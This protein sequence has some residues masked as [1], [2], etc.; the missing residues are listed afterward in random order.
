MVE[1]A[2]YCQR[3]NRF[4][5]RF[6]HYGRP[7]VIGEQDRFNNNNYAVERR[8]FWTA[9]VSGYMMGRVDRHYAV[10][11][12]G[13]LHESQIF[14][15]PADPPIYADLQRMGKFVEQSR[16]SFWRMAPHDELL[17]DVHGDIYCLAEPEVEYLLYFVMGGKVELHLP[18]KS[19]WYRWYN[20]RTGQFSSL[21][22]LSG[23][24]SYEFAA[25]DNE[26]W[27]LHVVWAL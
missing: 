8:G 17:A 7:T 11:S 16:L 27:V 26:D 24:V 5:E 12:A 4:G 20:P 2:A 1:M 21:Q 22:E 3:I 9:L 10:A 6:W 13:K 18:R 15:L 25:P 23:G 14:R 19:Y